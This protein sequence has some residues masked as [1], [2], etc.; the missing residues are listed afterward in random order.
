VL[1]NLRILWIGIPV[2]VGLFGW[3]LLFEYARKSIVSGAL[4]PHR[5]S[6]WWLV[7][8]GSYTLLFLLTTGLLL[9]FFRAVRR[10]IA[11]LLKVVCIANVFVVWLLLGLSAIFSDPLVAP[12]LSQLRLAKLSELLWLLGIFWWAPT[13]FAIFQSVDLSPRV[14]AEADV[15]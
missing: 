2:V 14:Q 6:I 7:I 10:R 4:T 13:L 12:A 3:K 15:S 11:G 5:L 8:G 9:G 1:R